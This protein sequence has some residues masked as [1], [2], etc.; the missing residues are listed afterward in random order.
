MKQALVIVATL[1]AGAFAGCL[2][3]GDQVPD[4]IL[5]TVAPADLEAGYYQF[6]HRGGDLILA[7]P[8]DN[9]ARFDLFNA[10]DRRLGRVELGDGGFADQLSIDGAPGEYVLN[11]IEL[12]VVRH[13]PESKAPEGEAEEAEPEHTDLEELQPELR[14]E[15]GG[16]AVTSFTPLGMHVERHI[17][18]DRDF[19]PAP[20][21]MPDP[22]FFGGGQAL[23]ETL[24]LTL[25]RTP[26]DIRILATGSAQDLE[27]KGR[28]TGGI[29]FEVLESFTNGQQWLMDL[30]RTLYPENI[31]DQA[32]EITLEATR[33]E[34]PVIL[35]AHS[36]SRFVPT[37]TAA[38]K[39]I[40]SDEPGDGVV[41]TYGELSSKPVRIELSNDATKLQAW[42]PPMDHDCEGESCDPQ[43]A[44]PGWLAI[45]GPSDA[46]VGSFMV[47]P[48]TRIE[49]PITQGGGYIVRSLVGPV[50]IGTDAVPR[51]FEMHP[52]ETR[53][54][55]VGTNAPGSNDA[56]GR[57]EGDINVTGVPYMVRPTMKSPDGDFEDFL[58]FGNC[59]EQGSV[60]LGAAGETLGFAGDR[61][62]NT[63]GRAN[64][65][66]PAEGLTF[67]QDGFSGN[68]GQ[69][70]LAVHSYIR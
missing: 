31:V 25:A 47:E 35:E 9:Y 23:S 48:G 21:G 32:L 43:L 33:Q 62:P 38:G 34:G 69:V 29:V 7:V 61:L 10:E 17:I 63:F 44:E 20:L 52:V 65:D 60:I 66:L 27:I 45:Y 30:G 5:G 42:L 11:I 1:M 41:F 57:V 50:T 51:D 3:G 13:G 70:A 49:V 64:L 16:R 36:Y 55:D 46:K 18:V 39:I 37:Q 28:G 6:T 4:Q 24:E 67:T 26:T 8:S 54:T 53:V 2:E 19:Q 22:G 68:C 58:T 12:H 59:A 14:I 40:E 15:S 56:Y